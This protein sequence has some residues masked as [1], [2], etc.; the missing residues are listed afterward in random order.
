[1][2]A[3]KEDNRMEQTED[4]DSS[5]YRVT[6]LLNNQREQLPVVLIVGMYCK[7]FSKPVH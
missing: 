6:S 4:Q 5:S 1:M 7:T 3:S 2:K